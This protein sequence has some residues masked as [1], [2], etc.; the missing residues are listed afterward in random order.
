MGEREDIDKVTHPNTLESL[1][2]DLRRLGLTT[3][4]VVLVHSSMSALGWACGGEQAVVMALLAAVGPDGTV[5]VPTHTSGN[6]DPVGWQY[7]PVPDGWWSTI[8]ETMPAFDPA[9]TPSRGMGRIPECLRS[10]P[11]TQRSN[12]P[13]VSFAAYGPLASQITAQHV[14]TPE[15]G[16]DTPLGALRELDAKVLLLGVGYDSCTCFHLGEVLGEASPLVPV[17]AALIEDGRRVWRQ[18]EDYEYDTDDFEACGAD[19]EATHLVGIGTVGVAQCR[20]FR[21][22]DAVDTAAQWLPT[23]RSVGRS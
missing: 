5:C 19:F 8:R 21:I 6:S 14:L 1:T 12:H 2:N 10:W 7:P 13:Q 18:F 15:F 9:V 16:P 20:L 4:D 11:G 22:R 23:H 3:G 17:V